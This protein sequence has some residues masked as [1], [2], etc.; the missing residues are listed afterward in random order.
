MAS[1]WFVKDTQD[2][3][4]N[5]LRD[6]Q[7]ANVRQNDP[8]HKQDEY[9]R[10]KVTVRA[11]VRWVQ[12]LYIFTPNKIRWRDEGHASKNVTKTLVLP[13]N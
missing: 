4:S 10:R 1:E 11:F 5:V 7:I 12:L 3:I 6:W 8:C 2:K 9:T 13:A